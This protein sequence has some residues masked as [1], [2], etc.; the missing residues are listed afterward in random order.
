[1]HYWSSI[2]VGCSSNN[3]RIY[4]VRQTA[5]GG[6]IMSGCSTYGDFSCTF[7][8]STDMYLLKTNSD[9]SSVW[10]KKYGDGLVDKGYSIQQTTDGGYIIGGTHAE[11]NNPKMY[12][13]KIQSDGTISWTK[14][15]Q[16][17]SG[18]YGG[19]VQQTS[20][21]GYALVGFTGTQDV[22]LLKTQN[23]GTL[24]WVKSYGGGGADGGYL[25]DN[26]IANNDG[27]VWPTLPYMRQANDGGYIIAG[28][29]ASYGSGGNDI[30]LIK[31]N[32]AGSTTASSG[33]T[34]G[35]PGF[36]LSSAGAAATPTLVIYHG[37]S[38]GT[39]D[40]TDYMQDVTGST[41]VANAA[42][43]PKNACTNVI[44]PVTLRYFSAAPVK[45]AENYNVYCNWETATEQNS[46]FFSVE[47]SPDGISF[48]QIGTVDGSG[49]S[50]TIK[51]YFYNDNEPKPGTSYYRLKQVDHDGK[52][53]Y[54][55][56]EE[57]NIKPFGEINIYPNP[58]AG[59][60]FLENAEEGEIKMIVT[61]LSGREIV[62]KTEVFDKGNAIKKISTEGFASGVYMLHLFTKTTERTQ[63]L[64]VLK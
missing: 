5:D 23:N 38:T 44:L 20:D 31:T 25:Y 54:S 48:S 29:T 39:K 15:Y 37:D 21:G 55:S 62:N 27:G 9:A 50:S 30:Y 40:Y 41:I 2:F 64:V 51:K 24:S 12:L 16:D 19:A 58:C 34:E 53:A 43:I 57:V 8:G 56:V 3:D 7:I 36:A 1:V 26:P 4:S 47:R 63:K 42:F 33:C 35:T 32:S 14:T 13:M 60:F 45:Q 17:A 49:N 61:D 10:A 52:Y 28:T 46:D 11:T 22:C 6:Y 59:Y 18:E